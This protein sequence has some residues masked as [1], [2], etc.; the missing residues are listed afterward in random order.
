MPSTNFWW[1]AA[2]HD[3]GAYMDFTRPQSG[4]F[5]GSNTG[6]S[7]PAIA[8]PTPIFLSGHYGPVRNKRFEGRGRVCVRGR[9]GEHGGGGRGSASVCG[10]CSTAGKPAGYSHTHC[11]LTVRFKYHQPEYIKDHCTKG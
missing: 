8:F 1:A 6:G 2:L 7:G 4:G 9:G 11:P 3:P 5:A 10:K